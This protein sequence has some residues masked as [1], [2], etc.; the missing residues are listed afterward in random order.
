MQDRLFG[1]TSKDLR[2]LAFELAEKNEISNTDYARDVDDRHSTSGYVF[3]LG[4]GAVSYSGKQKGISTST[5]QAEY[6]ALSHT[7][8]EAVF[9]RQLLAQF[10]GNSSRDHEAIT[11]REDNQAA[12][13]IS[14]NPARSTPKQNIFM[15]AI[16][17]LEK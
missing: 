14:N 8:K 2:S 7:T 1:L 9:L 17:L 4:D 3:I 10:E 5:A 13:A 11:I 12:L 16:T 15:S 6:V